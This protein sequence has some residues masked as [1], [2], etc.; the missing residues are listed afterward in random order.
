MHKKSR[1]KLGFVV[2]AAGVALAAC[3]MNPKE[4]WNISGAVAPVADDA[5]VLSI[6][7]EGLSG[8]ATVRAR[9]L[10]NDQDE[11]Y[12]LYRG[13]NGA[14]AEVIMAEA[15]NYGFG[16]QQGDRRVLDF[17]KITKETVG[18]WNIARGSKPAFGEAF[19]HKAAVRFYVLP[20][21]LAAGQSC[22]AFHSEF[23]NDVWDPE[24]H[25]F[26]NQLF[27]YYCAPNGKA[28]S[29]TEMTQA[30]DSVQIAGITKKA[31]Q[32]KQLKAFGQLN[33][34]P[35]LVAMVVDGSPKGETGIE[36][37][38]L[39]LVRIYGMTDGGS[40]ETK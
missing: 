4:Q 32:G 37:F 22:V 36:R 38:P 39:N 17:D 27:G 40:N 8:N 15:S 11:E 30:V 25:N 18:M 20:F 35:A 13:A 31:G 3:T 19:E 34:D 26:D 2:A 9:Y 16:A 23:N 33:N 29:Q 28:L 7:A 6:R 12:V 24:R 10:D 14:Q 21:T 1:N 5:G